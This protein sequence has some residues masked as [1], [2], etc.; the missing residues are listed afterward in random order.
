MNN[1]YPQYR[2]LNLFLEGE[3][4]RSSDSLFQSDT[5]YEFGMMPYDMHIKGCH[6]VP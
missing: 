5:C 6:T 2:N 4:R 1:S 3:K